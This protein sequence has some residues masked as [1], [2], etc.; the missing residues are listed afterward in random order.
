MKGLDLTSPQA[1]VPVLKLTIVSEGPLNATNSS[2]PANA[3]ANATN[4]TANATA[5]AVPA[6]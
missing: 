4:A 5:P 3:T 1:D 2:G 6:H